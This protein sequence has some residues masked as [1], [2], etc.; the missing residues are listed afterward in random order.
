M[1]SKSEKKESLLRVSL[2]NARQEHFLQRRTLV[3]ILVFLAVLLAVWTGVHGDYFLYHDTIANVTSTHETYI[4]TQTGNDGTYDYEEK[5]Y[6]QDITA[7]VKNG[8]YKGETVHLQSEYSQSQVYDTKYQKGDSIFI[9][10][11][12][13]T[14]SGLTANVGGI[15]RDYL[16]ATV[17]AALFGLFLL[18]GGNLG[19]LTILSLVLNMLAFYW[20]LVMYTKGVNILF[21]TIP[22]T[23]F[24][25]AMLLLFMLGKNEKTLIALIAT[26]ATVG[27]VTLLSAAVVRFSGRIDYDFMDYLSQPYTQHN[28]NLIFLSE[29]LVGGLGAV[30]DVVVTI[31]MTVSE[32][33]STGTHVTRK[34]LIQS[35]RSVGDDLVGTMI[36]LMFLTNIAS[37]IP[38]FVLF[39]RNGIHFSTILH[40]NVFFELARFL[41]GSIGTVLAIPVAAF[42]A[43]GWY[44]HRHLI[45]SSEQKEAR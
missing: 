31:V 16:I 35:C 32:I 19:I 20:V 8:K 44:E 13:R 26:L 27:A 2:R 29:V 10:S 38:S 3:K 42:I 36:N 1:A 15:K 30:M 21:M 4:K 6:R 22:M 14:A 9:E 45:D 25:T 24:F 7:V 11:V 33:V 17:L 41:T 34:T 40:Y 12:H 23:I 39:M 5:L 18:V 28:A 37:G 43:I